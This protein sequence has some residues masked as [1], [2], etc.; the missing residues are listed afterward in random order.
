LEILQNGLKWSSVACTATGGIHG[1]S[2]VC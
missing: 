1:N 2:G